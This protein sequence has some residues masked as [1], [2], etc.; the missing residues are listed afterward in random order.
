MLTAL[1]LGDHRHPGR[2]QNP[3]RFKTGVDAS[4]SPR[5]NV[6]RAARRLWKYHDPTGIAA[7]FES[8]GRLPVFT[9]AGVDIA[10]PGALERVVKQ[11]AYR[12]EIIVLCGD[13][14]AYASPTALNT[15]LQFWALR[16]RHTLYV[17]DSPGSCATLRRAL[18]SLACMWSSRIPPTKPKNDGICTQKFWDVRPQ[19]PSQ[20]PPPLAESRVLLASPLQP[21]APLQ[22]PAR[23]LRAATCTALWPGLLI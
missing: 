3:N 10:Q 8:A 22:S 12:G 9:E 17:S 14:S 20:H 5:H 11:V 7:T 18:P 1:D 16:L 6:T 2:H 23:A 21:T 15:V 19:L 13:G 4:H